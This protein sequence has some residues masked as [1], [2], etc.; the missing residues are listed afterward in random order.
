MNEPA[1]PS[2]SPIGIRDTLFG[3]LPLESWP[4][5]TNTACD[6]EP[7][8]TFVAARDFLAEGRTAD[9]VAAWR[10]ITDMAGLESRHY[11][12]AWHFLRACGVQPP[13][14]RA[15][16]L[17]GAVLE[18][19]MEGGLDLLAAY[20]EHTARY[21]N[22]SGAGVVWEHP[23]GSLDSTI[24]ALLQS[25][26]KVLQVIGPWE[27]PRPPAPPPGQVRMSFL[28]PLGL[29]FGQGPFQALAAD[30][31]AKPVIDAA[32]ALMQQLTARRR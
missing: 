19:P 24:D 7:W 13:P 21:Y 18:V 22:Y 28:A 14:G 16:V 8:R 2:T 4:P 26:N 20:P 15:K 30:P 27:K 31:L 11:L 6:E 3:D 17:M 25:G 32:T 5:P 10:C 12:Q 1:P 23:D 29:H 9:A